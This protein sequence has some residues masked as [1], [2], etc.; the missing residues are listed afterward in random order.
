M[1]LK[2]S[3]RGGAKQ[4]ALHLLNDIDNDHVDVHSIDG[5]I[6]DDVT[7]AL[8]EIYAISRATRCK[9]FMFSLSLSPPKD[10]VVTIEDYETAINEAAQRLGLSGQ[11]KVVLFH[12]KCGRRHCHVVFSRIDTQHMKAINLSFFKDRLNEL[13]H[14]LFLIHGWEVPE[15]FQNREHSNPLNYDHTCYGEAKKAKRDPK[16]IKALLLNC[17]QC[18][19]NRQSFESALAEKGFILCVGNRRG[20]LLVDMEG[21][22]YSLSRWLEEKPKILRK[23][24]GDPEHL[25]HFDEV[26]SM[27]AQT[28]NER[29]APSE[30]GCV[31]EEKARKDFAKKYAILMR[32]K[33]RLV[34]RQRQERDTLKVTQTKHR[35][36]KAFSRQQTLRK[37]LSGLWDRVTGTRAR[38]LAAIQTELEVEKVTDNLEKLKLSSR[39]LGESKTLQTRIDT[40]QARY[41]AE[42]QLAHGITAERIISASRSTIKDK[43]LASRIRREP[44]HL[45]SVLTDKESVFTKSD[46]ARALNGYIN[47]PQDYQNALTSILAS[48]EMVRLE[49]DE[50]EPLYSTRS[51]MELENT[52]MNNAQHMA[53]SGRFKVSPSLVESAITDESKKLHSEIGVALSDEQQ[54]AIRHITTSEQ[55]SCVVGVAGAG[56]STMLTAAKEAWEKAGYRVL[57][58]ALAGKAAKGLEEASGIPAKTIASYALSWRNDLHH[59]QEGDI[60]VVDEAGMI[61][62]KQMATLVTETKER[63]AKL[64]LVGDPEQLQP[65]NAGT[66]FKAMVETIGAKRLNSVHRQQDNWQRTASQHF[67]NGQTLE[68]LKAY[69][70]QGA[71]QLMDTVDD[72]LNALVYDYM[73]DRVIHG[74]TSSRLALAHRRDDVKAINET[75]RNMRKAIGELEDEKT[76]IT[77][78]GTRQ[79]AIGD[80]L[81]FTRNDRDIGVKNGMLGTITAMSGGQL[82]IEL[83]DKSAQEK[84]SKVT[85]HTR[86]YNDIDHGYAT[87]IHKSQG[88]TVDKTYIL[89]SLGLDR[90]LTYVAMTRHKNQVKLYAGRDEFST[91]QKL[92]AGLDRKEEK[93]S[94]LE[95]EE[96]ENPPPQ[97]MPTQDLELEW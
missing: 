79:F 58:A 16:T 61:G 96:A 41:E 63:G 83:D 72:A 66:P 43:A 10:T 97:E 48:D 14:E 56:K 39:H 24:L 76:Y 3:Q 81:L 95:F 46:I 62:S 2:G 5:F 4:L 15:G 40:L 11:P 37:G 31:E 71:I 69:E 38:Q 60:L 27:L 19:D 25:P 34:S 18:S 55:L 65:I 89:A 47:Q 53:V 86:D 87:T 17:W 6:S 78:N 84:P 35:R 70:E 90:N 67:A 49:R 21:K 68:A 45:L 1:M 91:V 82:T 92:Y 88:A 36:K 23:V 50:K 85:F 13:S 94:S 93:R 30:Q 59:L 29:E 7:G 73:E 22:P 44:V 64:V 8:H 75:I 12:E 28:Q 80:R 51:M 42:Q 26:Q 54:A 20:F 32:E 57:G 9:Q 74:D 77:T 52:L 33:E